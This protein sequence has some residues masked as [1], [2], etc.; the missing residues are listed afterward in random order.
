MTFSST[1]NSVVNRSVSHSQI[2][3]RKDILD[4]RCSSLTPITSP[5]L[6]HRPFQRRTQPY[7]RIS[8]RFDPPPAV[9]VAHPHR[10][11][12]KRQIVGQRILGDA[13]REEAGLPFRLLPV[14]G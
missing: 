8:N 14:G 9:R 4:I 6:L 7:D 12:V 13:E 2:L 10:L 3:I 5:R 11:S 1:A